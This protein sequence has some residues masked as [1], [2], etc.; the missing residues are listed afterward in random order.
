MKKKLALVLAAVM[1]LSLFSV[2][3]LASSEASSEASEIELGTGKGTPSDPIKLSIGGI[4]PDPYTTTSN[5]P[6]SGEALKLFLDEVEEMTE[7]GVTFD[8]YWNST[9]GGNPSME[10]QVMMGELDIHYGQPMSSNDSRYGAWN[11]PFIYNDYDEVVAAVNPVNGPVF[12]LSSQWTEENGVHLVLIS[13]SFFRGFLNSKREVKLPEDVKDMKI[14]TYEDEIVN[15]FWGSLGT[16]SIVP[17]SEIFSALQT[18]LVDAMEFMPSSIDIFGL[19]EVCDYYTDLKWQWTNGLCFT[20]NQEVWDSLDPSVQEI[21]NK[22][23]LDSFNYQASHEMHDQALMPEYV[24]E[25]LGMQYTELT[26][27]EHQ[28]WVDHAR[29]LDDT[30]KGLIGEEAFD[31][32]MAAVDEARA[33]IADGTAYHV[34]P[35]E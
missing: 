33:M 35:A 15:K 27:E 16:A 19:Q 34:N 24:S 4:A 30:F 31:A 14:R 13:M 2:P 26:E 8:C 12:E 11:L 28:A 23:A 9:L 6:A 20:M 5:F 29:S 32:Y 21:I 1:C 18:K 22:A 17:G 3:A 25:T 10:E 7:G